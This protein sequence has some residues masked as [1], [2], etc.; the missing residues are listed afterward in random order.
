MICQPSRLLT[1]GARLS[2]L[3]LAFIAASALMPS[4]A[5]AQDLDKVTIN[6]RVTD[7]NGAIIPGATVTAVLVQTNVERSVTA[8]DEG[9]Y[10]IIQLDPGEYTVRV[11]SAGFAKE[12]KT[13]I[14]T[15]AGQNIQLDFTLRPADV[16]GN[17]VVVDIGEPPPVD[18]TR[19]VVGGTIRTEE[20]EA[21]P[22][23]SRSP[24]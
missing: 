10:K 4:A 20:I 14:A 2:L 17:Q 21:L 11:S 6:G 5:H 15:V 3:L 13:N 19:T 12:E 9:R 23:V 22:N 1:M 16:T 7:Q 18:T 8:N 24:V